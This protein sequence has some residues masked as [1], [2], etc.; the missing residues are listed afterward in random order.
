MAFAVVAV[1]SG[2]GSGAGGSG[3]GAASEPTASVT[4]AG[5]PPEK[6]TLA[7]VDASKIPVR[8]H[9]TG[10]LMTARTCS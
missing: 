3:P 6:V 10:W 8:A 1:L 7:Q 9:P 5:P 4:P 2:C